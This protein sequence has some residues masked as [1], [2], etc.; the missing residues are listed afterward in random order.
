MKDIP[1]IYTLFIIFIYTK[2]IAKPEYGVIKGTV[3][4]PFFITKYY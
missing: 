3:T 2:S 1:L 4:T